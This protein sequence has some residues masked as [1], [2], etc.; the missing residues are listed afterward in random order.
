MSET[1]FGEYK[2]KLQHAKK[3]FGVGFKIR[4]SADGIELDNFPRPPDGQK[5][6]SWL[7]TNVGWD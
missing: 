5:R 2:A 3:A 4:H 7:A 1:A 6:E